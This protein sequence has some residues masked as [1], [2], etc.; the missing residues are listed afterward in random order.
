MKVICFLSFLFIANLIYS[1]NEEKLF[2]EASYAIDVNSSWKDNAHQQQSY[3]SFDTTQTLNIGYNKNTAVW[4]R[5]KLTNL[6]TSNEVKTWLT[7]DNNRIDSLVLFNEGKQFI[8]GDRTPFESPFLSTQAFEIDLKPNEIKTIYIKVKKQISYL[9]FTY[10][11]KKEASLNQQSNIKLALVSFVLGFIFLLLLYNAILFYITKNKLYG[12]Y[13]LN[14]FLTAIYILI[15][16]NYA[17]HILF[18]EFLYFSEL[19]IYVSSITFI[20]V[21]IFLSHFLDLKKL[22]PKNYTIIK[23]LNCINAAIICIT[24]IFLLIE[25]IDLLKLFSLLGYLNFILTMGW[26][27]WIAIKHLA[28]DKKSAM[29]VLFSFTPQLVWGFAL[30]LKSF[31]LI[32]KDFNVDTLAVIGLYEAVFFGYVLTKNYFET[33]QKNKELIQQISADNEKSIKAITQAQIRERRTI[34]NIIH[35][36]FGSKIAYVL[37]LLELN[38]K[39][40]AQQNITELANDIRDIS[41]KILPKSLDEGALISSLES[42]ISTLNKSFK[43]P[44]IVLYSYSFPEKINSEWVYDLYLISLEIMNNSIKHGKSDAISLEFFSYEKEYVFQF[45]DNGFGFDTQKTAKGFGIENIEKRV[46]YY[47]GSFE[48]N[49]SKNEG[50]VIQISIPKK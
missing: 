41:H 36:N 33:F 34:A 31:Q 7:F 3:I 22:Q 9:Y 27:F 25:Q 32:S 8:L 4:C 21:S 20:T 5:F 40:A 47:K 10:N 26:I 43:T 44:K 39:E 46:L 35:D 45:T 28:I 48:I 24:L 6:D 23:I 29:Y 50:T 38:K 15:S 13:I 19:R 16:T 18:R 30:I 2:I 12:Y 14:S 37:Q 11:F 42:Q 49:S 17:K 1:Q